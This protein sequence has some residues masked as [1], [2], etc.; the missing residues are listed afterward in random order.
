MQPDKVSIRNAKLNDLDVIIGLLN[1]SDLPTQDVGAANLASYIVAELDGTV[2]GVAGM[3]NCGRFG[4]L[5]S[6]AVAPLQ[7]NKGIASMLTSAALERAKIGRKNEVYLLTTTAEHYFS[8]YG[9][10][11]VP[12]DDTPT[13]IQ[14]TAEFSRLCPDSAIVMRVILSA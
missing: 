13:E 1:R 6:V 3:E 5:R 9:F 12:R 11:K 14:S 10:E 2:V 8:R 4:L 7:R